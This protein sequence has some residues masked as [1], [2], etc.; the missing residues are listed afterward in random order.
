MSAAAHA[1]RP[2]RRH[3]RPPTLRAGALAVAMLFSTAARGGPAGPVVA[4]GQVQVSRP[5]AQTTVITQGSPKAILNWNSFDVAAG[6]LV[7]FRQP[8][9]ASVILNRVGGG[10]ASTIAGRISANGQVFLVNPE[11]VL[12]GSGARVDVGSLVASTLAITDQDFL[13]GRYVFEGGSPYY[14]SVVNQGS[15]S[16]AERGTVALLGGQVRNDGTITARLGTIGLAGGGKVTLD[17]AGDGLTRITVGADA[18]NAL[19]ANGGALIADGGD[20]VMSIAAANA[21]SS[22]VLQNTGVVRARSLVERNG[23]ILLDGGS[24]GAVEVGGTLDAS[25]PVAFIDPAPLNGGKIQINGGD[26]RVGEGASIDASGDS[27]GVVR[28][29]GPATRYDTLTDAFRGGG[30]AQ[31]ITID[32]G[33]VINVEATR[34]PPPPPPAETPYDYRPGNGGSIALGSRQNAAVFGTL[35]ANGR[36]GGAGGTIIVASGAIDVEGLHNQ[37]DPLYRGNLVLRQANFDVDANLAGLISASLA[38]GTSVTL[39]A[40]PPA[41]PLT[42]T[43]ESGG[44]IN[45]GSSIGSNGGYANLTLAA[46]QDIVIAPSVSIAASGYAPMNVDLN[47]NSGNGGDGGSIYLAPGSGIFSNGGNVRL[48]GQSDPFNGAA[49][50][51]SNRQ[52]DGVRIDNATIDTRLG[53]PVDYPWTNGSI[54]IAGAGAAGYGSGVA[55]RNSEGASIVANDSVQIRSDGG[56]TVVQLYGGQIAARTGDLRIQAVDGGGAQ[57][58]LSDGAVMRAGGA[59]DINASRGQGSFGEGGM[60]SAV[61]LQLFDAVVESGGTLRISGSAGEGNGI[62]GRMFRSRIAAGSGNL[63]LSGSAG[64]GGTGVAI[65]MADSTISATNGDLRIVGTGNLDGIA[66]VVIGSDFDDENGGIVSGASGSGGVVTD[67]T[68]RLLASGGNLIVSGTASPSLLYDGEVAVGTRLTGLSLQ[69]VDGAV[70][71]DGLVGVAGAGGVP[72]REGLWLRDSIVAT[73]GSNPGAISLRGVTAASAPGLRLDGVSA[74]GAGQRGDIVLGAGNGGG[75]PMLGYRSE[76]VFA[77]AVQTSGAV[78]VRAEDLGSGVNGAAADVAITVS[79]SATGASGLVISPAAL[80]IGGAG[81]ARLVIGSAEHRG[82]I[83]YSLGRTWSG[84]LTLQNGGAGS[85]GIDIAGDLQASGALTLSSGGTVS[86]QGGTRIAAPSLLLNGTRPESNFQLMGPNNSTARFAAVFNV[87]KSLADAAHGDVN[88]TSSG[89][90]SVTALQGI[91]FATPGFDYPAGQTIS[92]AGGTVVAGDLLLR[93]GGRLTLQQDVRTIGS[94][95]TLVAGSMFDNSGGHALTPGADGNWRVFADTW[96][97]EARGGLQPSRPVPNVYDCTYGASCGNLAGN[98]FIYREQPALT[99]QADPQSRMYGDANPVFTYTVTGLIN[100]DL[101]SDAASGA[102]SSP[103][104]AASNAGSYAIDGSYTSPAGYA[105]TANPGTLTVTRAPLAIGADDQRKVYGGADPRLTSSTS[106]LRN[107]DTLAQLGL[108]PVLNTATGK[109]AGAGLHPIGIE[110]VAGTTNYDISY[111][112][113]TL[114]VDRAQLLVTADDQRKVYGATDPT[115]SASY[116]GFQYDD[117][118]AVV[119]GLRLQTA[120]GAAATAGNHPIA[121]AGGAAPNYGVTYRPGTV[122]VD[123]ASLLDR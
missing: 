108:A 102:Y 50:G 96:R 110:G 31:T 2:P 25:A 53:N 85:A 49:R 7:D 57:V 9:A 5:N 60:A 37:A 103:A 98:H 6:E 79:D 24:L 119:D 11:G 15:L 118:A 90:V 114:T 92:A 93:A 16:A 47:A 100:G 112:P 99:L 14:S 23:R 82:A 78:N 104:G 12:F 52:A 73:S 28:V 33:A 80:G 21:F 77:N 48:F 70:R 39:D 43:P 105:L 58:T 54:A 107:G 76:S 64:A 1:V 71:L 86:Q 3:V 19:V 45:V 97:G 41:S 63:V 13:A 109:A 75:A 55:I 18:F 30:Y 36:D 26:V 84:D 74:G 113:G 117:S 89:D 59:I 116:S 10:Q 27:G 122:T 115:L 62:G 20:I 106:G 61:D 121:V 17:F 56:G 67:S 83:S 123:N 120:V 68:A 94:D 4:S 51:N 42:G 101:A 111:H 34:V 88:Y 35:R 46:A 32:A 44:N 66:G 40:T 38:N 87:P 72:A 22:A 65:K 91:G 95:I 69:A 81:P 29:G 8:S